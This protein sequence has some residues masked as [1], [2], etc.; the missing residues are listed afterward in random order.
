[1]GDARA[2]GPIEE[3]QLKTNTIIW[4]VVAILCSS[5]T[6]IVMGS[7]LPVA[8]AELSGGGPMS[9]SHYQLD[10]AAGGVS[11]IGESGFSSIKPGF[12]GELVDLVK[13]EV[14]P[15]GASVPEEQS[16]QLAARIRCDDGTFFHDG[17]TFDW[18]I[19]SGPLQ[20]SGDG[21][22]TAE[23]V[24]SDTNATVE[25]RSTGLAGTASLAVL[26]SDLD[27]YGPYAHDDVADDW[28]VDHFGFDNP[29]GLAGADPDEDNQDN[30]FEFLAGTDPNLSSDRFTVSIQYP[31]EVDVVFSPVASGRHYTIERAP[32]LE[33][34]SWSVLTNVVDHAAGPQF[35]MPDTTADSPVA[36]YRVLVAYPW[37]SNP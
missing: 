27:N 30:H 11:R 34:A 16:V 4:E 37:K 33:A 23:A 32:I 31:G 36:F 14:S 25:A 17:Y 29:L 26:N 9:S 5:T 28:Q 10:A 19:L 8:S 13:V 20:S 24:Y 1:M 2:R 15:A 6:G 12:S 7:S 22:V 18:D 35:M 21:W 3:S